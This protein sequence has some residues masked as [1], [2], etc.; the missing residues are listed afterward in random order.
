[1][2]ISLTCRSQKEFHIISVGFF[3]SGSQERAL[4]AT[5]ERLQ[6]ELGE[7]ALKRSK[8]INGNFREM[9]EELEP[10]SVQLVV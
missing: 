3:F 1:M 6:S 2:C 7:L 9:P 5:R 4:E 8:L 10:L